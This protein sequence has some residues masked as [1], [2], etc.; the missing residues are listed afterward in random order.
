MTLTKKDKIRP[1]GQ[2]LLVIP[3]PD[4]GTYGG[5]VIVRPETARNKP[6]VGRVVAI[7]EGQ[8]DTAFTGKW[9]PVNIGDLVLYGRWAGHEV[10]VEGADSREETWPRI[11]GIEEILALV[12]RVK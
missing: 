3:E 9:P 10:E 12:E 11:I 1:M 5:G 6:T 8:Q 4:S 2:R 7:G